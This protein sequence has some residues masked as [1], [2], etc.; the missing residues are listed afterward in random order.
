MLLVGTPGNQPTV[1][2]DSGF[3][4]VYPD[5]DSFDHRSPHWERSGRAPALLRPL[6]DRYLALRGGV[7]MWLDIVLHILVPMVV[8]FLIYFALGFGPGWILQTIFWV[9]LTL[10]LLTSLLIAVECAREG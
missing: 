5:S 4:H 10:L 7:Q 2:G 3:V 8:G 9:I 1:D 6:A